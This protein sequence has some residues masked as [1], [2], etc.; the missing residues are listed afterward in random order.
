MKGPWRRPTEKRD[1]GTVQQNERTRRKGPGPC[2]PEQKGHPPEYSSGCFASASPAALAS[3]PVIVTPFGLSRLYKSSSLSVMMV[4]ATRN[5]GTYTGYRRAIV[6]KVMSCNVTRPETREPTQVTCYRVR[7]TVC[8]TPHPQKKG[9]PMYILWVLSIKVLPAYHSMGPLCSKSPFGVHLSKHP[10]A[11]PPLTR[12]P[13]T[14]WGVGSS[15]TLR[16]STMFFDTATCMPVKGT[17]VPRSSAT[18][19]STLAA[20]GAVAAAG[21]AA[22]AEA[23][24]GAAAGALRGAGATLREARN[25]QRGSVS[26]SIRLHAPPLSRAVPSAT[27]RHTDGQTDIFSA[28]LSRVAELLSVARMQCRPR[29]QTDGRACCDQP[30]LWQGPATEATCAERKRLLQEGQRVP[31]A[32]MHSTVLPHCTPQAALAPG[33]PP[34]RR[35]RQLSA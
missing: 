20:G 24:A 35:R 23:A 16:L 27:D 31:G 2:P 29:R 14:S 9:L 7:L 4:Y 10:F 32:A 15:R 25:S 8:F 17:V 3:R 28:P 22:G 1:Q 5:S 12:P 30:I 13:R 19:V 18:L 11:A 26:S 21:F 6:S 33:A 34:G